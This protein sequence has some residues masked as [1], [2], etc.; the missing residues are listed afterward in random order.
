M[1]IEGILK[2]IEG[3][4][5]KKSINDESHLRGD[6]RSPMVR[7]VDAILTDAV[8]N[9]ASD[10]H[11]EPEELFSVSPVNATEGH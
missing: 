4:S 6:Y 3:T 2:E 1:S 9:G 5:D 11:F 10:L 8:H 7:L